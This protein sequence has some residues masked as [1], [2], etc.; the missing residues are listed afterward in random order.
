M[1]KVLI[2][3]DEFP[4][5]RG[6]ARLI[7][8]A[9]PDF[10][11][12]M[13]AKNGKEV[14]EYL[15][16]HE[17]DVVF[18][19]IN[20]PIVDGLQVLKYIKEKHPQIISVVISGYQDF[21][22]A[23][24][25]V[26]YE[27]KRYLIKPI[28]N[29]EL[30][31]LLK[32]LKEQIS[33]Q[34]EKKKDLLLKQI[35]FGEKQIGN[36]KYGLKDAEEKNEFKNVYPIYIVA[37]AYCISDLEESE[38]DNEFW[39]NVDLRTFLKKEIKSLV[40]TY[41]YY[42]KYFNEMI[43]LLETEE[44]ENIELMVTKYL[45]RKELIFPIAIVAGDVCTDIFEVGN[46]VT[47]LRKKLLRN[48]KYGRC[49]VINEDNK[50]PSFRMKKSTEESL[51]YMI[52]QGKFK[53]FQDLLVVIQ[54][55]MEEEN[56][57]Q[58]DLEHTL[59]KI[60]MFIQ[61]YETGFL[62]EEISNPTREINDIIMRSNSINEIFEEFIFWCQRLMFPNEEENTAALVQ[63]VDAFIQEHYTERITT[64]M[65]AQEVGLVPSYLSRLF[66]E[67][68][69][70]TPN[71]YIQ[72]IRIERSKE[73][74]LNCPTVLT[75]DIALMVGYVDSSYFFKVFKKNTGVSPSEYRMRELSK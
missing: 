40:G 71:H 52:K 6:I 58:Y 24:Q 61:M 44:V 62:N 2:A 26:R 45:Q 28:E 19:D 21:L 63:R 15:E 46:I 60:L 42:G 66:R 47:Q 73:M 8:K 35:L 22:Y 36:N 65:L 72:N 67:Y 3:E 53:G 48:W 43:V 23:Q 49:E 50:W 57:T 5:L 31:A 4:L 38:F 55:Q 37:K 59:K 13:L 1:I 27:A 74:L 16:N 51:Q 64:K 30:C 69:G 25:A 70:V 29:H 10:S 34:K 68:K 14:L 41:T 54:K 18:T 20:M 9:D 56:I 32:E 17:V 7:E 75:T 39:N 11:V 12:V 33:C